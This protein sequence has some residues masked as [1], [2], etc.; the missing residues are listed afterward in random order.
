MRGEHTQPVGHCHCDKEK[1]SSDVIVTNHVKL[2]IN[3]FGF[4]CLSWVKNHHYGENQIERVYIHIN[5]RGLTLAV[6]LG[7]GRG[8]ALEHVRVVNGAD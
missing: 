3:K 8:R 6:G 5:L 7:G 1:I 4:L 2:V